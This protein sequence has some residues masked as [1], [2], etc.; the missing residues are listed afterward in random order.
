MM[1]AIVT[2]NA[3]TDRLM[4]T[5][6]ATNGKMDVLIDR[7]D[8]RHLQMASLMELCTRCNTEFEFLHQFADQ[9][10]QRQALQ[11]LQVVPQTPSASAEVSAT[12]TSG[13]TDTTGGE[14]GDALAMSVSVMS[15]EITL[16][17]APLDY[18]YDANYANYATAQQDYDANA[19]RA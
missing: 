4:Q 7:D 13:T 8:D 18:D 11:E 6:L 3:K 19:T 9:Q 1:R 14:I 15:M 12:T 16:D 10:E 5:L 2:V 17:N